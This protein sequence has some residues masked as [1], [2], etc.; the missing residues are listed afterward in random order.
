MPD[1]HH[2][3]HHTVQSAIACVHCCNGVAARTAPPIGAGRF[4]ASESSSPETPLRTSPI[5]TSTFLDIRVSLS[6]VTVLPLG[7]WEATELYLNCRSSL[8]VH[9]SSSDLPLPANGSYI[10]LLDPWLANLQ[11]QKPTVF[12]P[13]TTGVPP[14][15]P[16]RRQQPL[17]HLLTFQRGIIPSRIAV[18]H[19]TARPL[20]VKIS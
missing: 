3:P 6:V 1:F 14:F 20:P 4:A 9:P 8:S 7:T 18:V 19:Q 2:A 10:P 15:V 12:Q 16:G 5:F 13:S 17:P 11:R